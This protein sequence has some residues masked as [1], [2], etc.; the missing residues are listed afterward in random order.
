M[1]NFSGFNI[2]KYLRNLKGLNSSASEID[3]V[4]NVVN[5]LLAPIHKLIRESANGINQNVKYITAGDSTRSVNYC[6]IPEYYVQQLSKIGVAHYSNAVPGQT[7]KDWLNNTD[8]NTL[9]QAINNSSGIDGANTILEFSMGINDYDGINTE[10]DIINLL[11]NAV[12]A[13]KTVMP[14]ANI[15]LVRPNR[16]ASTVRDG[17]LLNAYTTVANELNL[18]VISAYDVISD[19]WRNP[20][21]Y[22]DDTHPNRFGARRI[23]NKIFDTI[24]PFDL[25]CKFT[26]EEYNSQTNNFANFSLPAIVRNGGWTQ[27]TGGDNN[28]TSWY[29]LEEVEVTPNIEIVLHTLGERGNFIYL[30]EN[31]NYI[32][33]NNPIRDNNTY[34]SLPPSN[35]K[36]VRINI[37]AQASTYKLLND[38]PTLTLSTLTDADIH[39]PN[40][41]LNNNLKLGCVK[42]MT[43]NGVLVDAYGKTGT[44]GQYLKIDA[45]DKM[46]WSS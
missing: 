31:K 27:A 38:I 14:K 39:I 6:Y 22:Y 46:K 21:F 3:G 7:I 43:R 15:I 28:S 33:V 8:Q 4:A 17:Y 18:L 36:F 16:T 2:P 24:I 23:I 9:Q 45:N 12:T 32:Y 11:R 13:Y 42:E 44:I 41:I 26:L 5:P 29:S 25:K 10:Q 30:D 34:K 20:L 1:F 40:Y 35:A 37:S 19:Y